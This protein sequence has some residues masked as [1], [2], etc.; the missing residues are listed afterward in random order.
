MRQKSEHELQVERDR[1]KQR[2][3]NDEVAALKDYVK[4]QISFLSNPPTQLELEEV[5]EYVLSK[6]AIWRGGCHVLTKDNAIEIVRDVLYSPVQNPL[7]PVQNSCDIIP[8]NPGRPTKLTLEQVEDALQRLGRGESPADIGK[9]YDV[10]RTTISRLRS[11]RW[12][13]KG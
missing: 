6:H 2:P 4:K 1:N 12:H 8:I 5:V 7:T 11:D 13:L 10:D 9:L 3:T